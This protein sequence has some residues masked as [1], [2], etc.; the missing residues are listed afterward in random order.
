MLFECA[1]GRSCECETLNINLGDLNSF[2]TTVDMF[3]PV[4]GIIRRRDLSKGHI[5]PEI[6]QEYWT[7]WKTAVYNFSQAF[8]TKETDRLPAMSGMASRMPREIFGDYIAG[9]WT[10]DLLEELLWSPRSSIPTPKRYEEWVGPSFSWVSLFCNCEWGLRD[11]GEG[12][13]RVAEIIDAR[14]TPATI[15]PLGKVKGAFVRLRTRIAKTRKGVY[16]GRPRNK[17]NQQNDP[18]NFDTEEDWDMYHSRKIVFFAMEISHRDDHTRAL[19]VRSSERMKGSFERV[20]YVVFDNLDF[21]K[22]VEPTEL[23]LS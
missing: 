6:T 5:T 2:S 17:Y 1:K 19:L 14:A 15:D 23:T 21:F 8:L 4:A 22:G 10:G 3:N 13:K 20:G 11:L 12:A 7:A 16:K 18:Y 9:L